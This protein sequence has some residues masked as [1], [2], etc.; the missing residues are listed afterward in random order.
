MECAFFSEQ[1]RIGQDRSGDACLCS[2]YQGGRRRKTTN[3]RLL[4]QQC[5]LVGGLSKLVRPSLKINLKK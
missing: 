3:S 1:K 4:G 5:E 2:G